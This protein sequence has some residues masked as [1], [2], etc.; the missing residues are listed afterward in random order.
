[1]RRHDREMPKEFAYEVSDKC[2][3]AVLSMI[4][5]ENMPYCIPITIARHAD[6]LYFH[7]A[8]E[9]KKIDALR[10]CN[11]V[12]LTCVGETFRPS[13]K[14]TTEYES[15]IIRGNALEVMDKTEK[16]YALELLCLRHT[17]SNMHEFEAAI[18]KSLNRTAVWKIEISEIT[19][20]RKKYGNDGKAMKCGRV[21]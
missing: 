9:G 20:K 8:K 11:V 19:G 15:A 2:Q 5:T 13:N 6:V 3:W 14:F 18:D 4:D 21:E 10:A 17:P 1:M 16:I 7:C 12:C